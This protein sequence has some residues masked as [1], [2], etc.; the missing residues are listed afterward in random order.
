MRTIPPLVQH[1][2]SFAVE[3]EAERREEDNPAG[4]D[5]PAGEGTQG[6][7]AAGNLEEDTLAEADS[8]LSGT[9]IN[10]RL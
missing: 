6:S 9:L 7:L 3:A 2:Y 4:E 5:S 10:S 1:Y 8:R